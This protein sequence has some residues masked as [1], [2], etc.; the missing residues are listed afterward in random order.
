MLMVF[1]ST[2]LGK[3]LFEVKYNGMVS[4]S[5]EHDRDTGGADSDDDV[6]VDVDG[7]GDVDGDVDGDDDGYD[8]D[9]P[10]L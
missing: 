8:G 7:D 1:W 2:L 9:Y 5:T 4:L 3:K 6:D 10:R